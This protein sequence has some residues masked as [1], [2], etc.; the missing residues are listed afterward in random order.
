MISLR[1]F[2]QQDTEQLISILNDTSVTQFLSSKIPSPYTASDANWWITE[3][4]KSELI[5]AITLDDQLIG[6]V[7]VLPGEFEFNRSGELG[8][9]LAKE[10]WQQGIT[11]KAATMLLETVFTKTNIVRVFAYVCEDNPA[12]MK[13]LQKL[14]F[15]QDAILKNAMFKQQQFFNAHL[16]SLIKPHNKN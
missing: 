11:A 16:F 5:K 12:S 4:S 15:E 9:W 6:C 14:G 8:Y 3:G 2:Q 10:Y 7:S 13:L 1:D